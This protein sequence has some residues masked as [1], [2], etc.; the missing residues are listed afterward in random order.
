MAAKT[1]FLKAGAGL[2]GVIVAAAGT[3][4]SWAV[5]E[6]KC[7]RLLSSICGTAVAEEIDGASAEPNLAPANVADLANGPA[8]AS[9]GADTQTARVAAD[10]APM[11]KQRLPRRAP[12]QGMKIKYHLSAMALAG[13]ANRRISASWI[14]SAKGK[15]DASCGPVELVYYNDV[16]LAER[17]ASELGTA[18]A[19]AATSGAPTCE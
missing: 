17:L 9:S 3:V 5:I 15:A 18:I 11:V 16:S 8:I 10:V 12:L 2:S 19:A 6:G 1:L 13:G 4:V 14:V 7:P